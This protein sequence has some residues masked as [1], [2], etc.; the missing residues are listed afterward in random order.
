MRP[1]A[2][3]ATGEREPAQPSAAAGAVAAAASRAAF[4]PGATERADRVEE[5]RGAE[6]ARGASEGA[7]AGV[8]PGTREGTGGEGRSPQQHTLYSLFT[9]DTFI[10][11][12]FY[13]IFCPA[14]NLFFLFAQHIAV[15]VQIPQTW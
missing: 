7:A 4:T 15:I 8:G 3:A 12:I 9:R 11:T 5:R 13:F 2:L 10:V 14:Y 1:P 6:E